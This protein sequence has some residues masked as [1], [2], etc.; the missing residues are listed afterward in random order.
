ML[1]YTPPTP[2]SIVIVQNSVK[3]IQCPKLFPDYGWLK[4][5]RKF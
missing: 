3:T 1:I 2:Q 5:V 4:L